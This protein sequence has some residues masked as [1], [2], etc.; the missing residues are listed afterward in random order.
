MPG[1][2]SRAC[3]TQAGRGP[4]SRADDDRVVRVE[5]REAVDNNFGG[6][7]RAAF[8]SGSRSAYMLI[9]LRTVSPRPLRRPAARPPLCHPPLP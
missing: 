9:Y 5:A 8:P 4:R 2:I 6:A 3:L 1:D 7:G